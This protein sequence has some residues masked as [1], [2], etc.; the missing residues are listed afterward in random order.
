MNY[1]DIKQ[2][3]LHYIALVLNDYRWTFKRM[4]SNFNEYAEIY[5]LSIYILTEFE[6]P[7]YWKLNTASGESLAYYLKS[8]STPAVL[9]YHIKQWIHIAIHF[10]YKYYRYNFLWK[11]DKTLRD[12]H[13]IRGDIL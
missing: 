1:E 3:M 6:D 8:R 9:D 4:N 11:R 12:I 7:L 2:N 10:Y 13:N 5:N